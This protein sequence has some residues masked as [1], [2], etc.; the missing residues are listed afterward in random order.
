MEDN[1]KKLDNSLQTELALLRS[2]IKSKGSKMSL[3][4]KTFQV[5]DMGTKTILDTFRADTEREAEKI[6]RKNLGYKY[7]GLDIYLIE[8]KG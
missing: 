1:T 7:T 8:V 2:I 6:V 4:P 3:E 5:I